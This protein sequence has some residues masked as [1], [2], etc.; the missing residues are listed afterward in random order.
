MRVSDRLPRLAI[1][2]GKDH[3]FLSFRGAGLLMT[4]CLVEMGTDG[5]CH[6]VR[7]RR[8]DRQ[9]I[10][11]WGSQFRYH[12]LGPRRWGGHD[13]PQGFGPNRRLRPECPK[14]VARGKDGRQ[15]GE[16]G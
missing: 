11:T 14:E 1:E 16:Q 9:I 10:A 15:G 4:R 12:D 13:R 6:H 8:R 2:R 5:I 3:A 7:A